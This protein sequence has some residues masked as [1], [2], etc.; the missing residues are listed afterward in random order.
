MLIAHL[1]AGYLLSRRLS[2]NRDNRAWLIFAGL[3][4]SI[5]P[6]F[7]LLWFYLIDDRQHIHHAYLFHWPLFWIALASVAFALARL[8]RWSAAVP[9]IFG[10]LSCLLLHMVLDSVAAEI[11]WLAPFSEAEVN[12]VQVPATHDWWVW[13]F[14]LHWTFLVEIAIVCAAAVALWRDMRPRKGRS[15]ALV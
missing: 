11:A 2:K 1:P 14:V 12:L 3:C 5:L 15:G 6:D 4:A 8:M 7:D 13:S 9:F 10:M